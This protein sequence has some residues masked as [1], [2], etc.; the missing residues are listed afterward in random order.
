[1]IPVLTLSRICPLFIISVCLVVSA[2]CLSPGQDD[3]GQGILVAVTIPPQVEMVR[4]IGDSRVDVLV[5]VPPG[6]DPHTYEPSPGLVARASAADLYL[7]LGSGL[8]PIEDTL[9][10]RLQAMNQ[11]LVVVNTSAGVDYLGSGERRDPH[12]WLSLKNARI[13]AGNTRDALILA[14][15]GYEEMYR[16]NA[17]RYI[18]RIDDLDR[19][20]SADFLREDPGMILVTHD[21]WGYFARDYGLSIIS[22]EQEGKEPT[23]KDLEALITRA[24]AQ[25]VTVVFSEAQENRREA[26]AIADEIGGMVRV[27]DPLAPDYLANMERIATAFAGS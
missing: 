8:F 19:N 26:Q 11:T 12:V 25:G 16:E 14:D 17:D 9:A 20:I 3:Q 23:A 24:R 2:G 21:A 6:S 13:M 22:I 1:M 15:P 4:E 27:I 18:A 5:L 10:D 7:T